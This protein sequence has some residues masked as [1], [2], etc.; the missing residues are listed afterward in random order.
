[1]RRLWCPGSGHGRRLSRVI[2]A[3]MS[4]VIGITPARARGGAGCSGMSTARFVITGVT[5]QGVSVAE[6][7]RRHGVHRSWI[8]KLLA[9]YAAE[10]EAAFEPRSRRPRSS[11]NPTP[12]QTVMVLRELRARLVAAGLDA[13]A[14][15]LAWH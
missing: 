1:M 7:A 4:H 12:P 11:P 15:T 2:G 10:G 6:V 14:E 3:T 9:R 13:G 5:L 8:Y